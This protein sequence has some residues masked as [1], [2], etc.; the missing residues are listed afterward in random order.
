MPQ[1]KRARLDIIND[2]LQPGEAI[3][4]DVLALLL[5][6]GGGLKPREAEGYVVLSD[7]RLISATEKHGILLDVAIEQI[8]AT[9]IERR[10]LMAHLIVSLK[11]GTI[12]TLVINKSS[13][14]ALADGINQ[15]TS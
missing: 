3:L 14:R 15:M 4:F 10:F 2:R 11:D 1:E 8:N 9:T 13:A 5:D 6:P 7:R 12:H